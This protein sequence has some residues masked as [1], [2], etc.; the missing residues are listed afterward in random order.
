MFSLNR[1]T[2]AVGVVG[3][4]GRKRVGARKDSLAR[5]GEGGS[6]GKRHRREA[7]PETETEAV[8]G[9][10]HRWRGRQ[11]VGAQKGS[12]AREESKGRGPGQ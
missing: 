4:R 6:R 1:F 3:G 8:K 10:H 12:L 2:V 5:E 9:S 11:R 7:S